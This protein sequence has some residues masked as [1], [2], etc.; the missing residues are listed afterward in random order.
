[1]TQKG[2]TL[3]EL[4]VVIAIIGVL[5]AVGAVAF[6]GFINSAKVN[7]VKSNLDLAIKHVSTQLMRCEFGTKIQGW[8]GSEPYDR[9]CDNFSSN[10]TDRFIQNFGYTMQVLGDDGKQYPNPFNSND[11]AF[12]IDY[13]IPTTSQVGR[14]HCGVNQAVNPN[15]I[16]CYARWGAG[17]NDYDTK[18]TSNP[19]L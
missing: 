4:L 7:V 8:S 16:K 14:V 13:D 6:Q 5:A 10:T 15:L 9:D 18:S 12:A 17:E 1:M 11:R 3:I 19:Y 2:F